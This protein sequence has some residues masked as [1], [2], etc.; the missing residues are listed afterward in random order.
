MIIIGDIADGPAFTRQFKMLPTRYIRGRRNML[1]TITATQKFNAIH[2]II[3]GNATELFV[4][5]P[6]HMTDL[7]TFIDEVS[8]IIAN[9]TSVEFY[10]TA[11]T[12]PYSFCS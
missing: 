4:Y 6:R 9:K 10:Q 1:S 5:R 7:Q 2:P 3:G 11:A 8:A 12:D